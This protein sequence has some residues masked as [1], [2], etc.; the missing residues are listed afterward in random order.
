MKIFIT[1]WKKYPKKW[2]NKN[3]PS[4]GLVILS[5][6]GGPVFLSQDKPGRTTPPKR[7]KTPKQHNNQPKQET[8]TQDE[9]SRPDA[10]KASRRQRLQTARQKQLIDNILTK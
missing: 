4:T 1:S 8:R 7:T 6:A 9:Q 3:K 10:F 2:K 5:R